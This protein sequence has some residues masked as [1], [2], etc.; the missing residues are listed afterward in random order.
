MKKNLKR[1]QRL[2]CTLAICS[3][4][5]VFIGA[6]FTSRIEAEQESEISA[7]IEEVFN[8]IQDIS[9]NVR[10]LSLKQEIDEKESNGSSSIEEKEAEFNEVSLELN[11]QETIVKEEAEVET[12]KEEVKDTPKESEEV[13]EEIKESEEEVKEEPVQ[14]FKVFDMNSLTEEEKEKIVRSVIT[15]SEEKRLAQTV[16]GE[17]R[18][19]N[20][21][22][23]SAVIWCIYNRLDSG[24]Y[25]SSISSVVTHNQ[26]HGWF[27]SQKHPEWSHELVRDVTIRYAMEKQGY[28]NVGRTLPNDYYFFSG[29]DGKNWFRKEYKSNS[30]WDFSYS[31]PYNGAFEF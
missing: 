20:L 12:F 24:K 19:N 9:N 27:E 28:K 22:R 10:Y 8:G 11:E 4:V 21:M 26:F 3:V 18:G 31:D 29:R 25:G 13:K 1:L 7:P 14:E 16:Y 6:T 17:D 30:Y 15:E 23:R 5:L 2:V